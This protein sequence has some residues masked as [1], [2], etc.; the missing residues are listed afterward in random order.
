M[1]AKVTRRR[2]ALLAGAPLAQP[3]AAQQPEAEDDLA[4][5]R[6]NLQRNRETLAKSPLPMST[7]PAFIFKP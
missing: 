2:L 4:I 7:E 6:R 1:S 5:Q 3:A